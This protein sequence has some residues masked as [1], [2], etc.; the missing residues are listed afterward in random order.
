MMNTRLTGTYLYY[1]FTRGGAERCC[2]RE[3]GAAG[4]WVYFESSPGEFV[5]T[6]KSQIGRETVLANLQIC[7]PNAHH[8]IIIF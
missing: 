7:E 5:I 3:R 1:C 4:A 6:T 2:R 8:T